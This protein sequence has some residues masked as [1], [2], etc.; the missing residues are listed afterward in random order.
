MTIIV[1]RN[2]RLLFG[3]RC[4]AT[5][6]GSEE[7]LYRH[8]CFIEALPV[9]IPPEQVARLI[10]RYPAYDAKE[11]ALP[12]LRRLDAV[13]RIANCVF[14]MPDFLELEQKIFRMIRNGYL[15]RNP[16]DKEWIRQLKSGFPELDIT[17]G[18]RG[19]KPLMRSTAAGIA[20][21]GTSGVGK[22]TMVE[23][24]LGLY[25]QVIVH[26][27]YNGTA[28]DQQQLVWLKLE[29]PFDG[30]L[31]GL[32]MNF[33]E[34]VDA[35]VG[36]RYVE[37]YREKRLPVDVLLPIMAIVTATLGMG[38]LVIDE[39]Q[40]LNE[41]HSGGAQTMLNFFIQ[42]TS[43]IGIPVV[44]V[45]TYKAFSLFSGEFAMARRNAGQ[46]DIIISNLKR[47][48]YWE[49]FLGELWAYQ[50]TNEPTPLTPELSRVMYE[51][52]QG[53]VDIAV[54]LYMLTQ[55]SVIGEEN[56]LLT[57][58]RIR[59]VARNNF[60]AVG[61]MIRALRLNDTAALSKIGDLVPLEGQIDKFLS[62]SVKRVTLSGTLDTLRNQEQQNPP[63]TSELLESPEGQIAALLV[64]A[65]YPIVVSQQCA[66][67]AV[68]RFSSAS[69]MKLASSEAFR[70]AS[71]S[72]QQNEKPAPPLSN[73]TPVK[74]VKKISLSGDLREIVAKGIKKKKS[75]YDALRE[76]GLIKSALEFHAGI[77]G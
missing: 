17:N 30:S 29:C 69:N 2:N 18:G 51:E 34:A 25:P 58:R 32:C 36:T 13:H 44:L 21:I 63:V 39:I 11:R 20:M 7:P 43:T 76:E 66:H 65:G 60:H 72:E 24:I 70:L 64:G 27:E 73:V 6:T 5:Y 71:E 54:K 42:L 49:H 52:T 35:I 14:P 57:P 68:Q 26:T 75:A 8:N 15:V 45:G 77:G 55:W 48:E 33:F 16:L 38:V 59:D 9:S 12:P 40:R 56:E 50:W 1:K 61:P 3:E 19:F 37:K 74:P 47:D 41:A 67:Q 23:S 28:F 46:G 10:A 53:I 31:R 4:K 62:K 22:S